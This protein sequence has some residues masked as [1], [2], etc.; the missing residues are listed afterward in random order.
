MQ[1]R[2]RVAVEAGCVADVKALLFCLPLHQ[3]DRPCD[4]TLDKSLHQASNTLE[5]NAREQSTGNTLLHCAVASYFHAL[6]VSKSN[7]GKP[8]C[9]FR[10][11][12]DHGKQHQEQLKNEK[13]NINENS[14]NDKS[15][16]TSTSTD[17]PAIFLAF[18]Q[19]L[20]PQ[21]TR[22][23]IVQ[24]LLAAGADPEQRNLM[25]LTPMQLL[26]QLETNQSY[27]CKLLN[28]PKSSLI[29]A[30]ISAGGRSWEAVPIPCPGIGQALYPVWQKH[31]ED[32][33]CLV[34]RLES[35]EKF[36]MQNILLL[37]HRVLPGSGHLAA[38]RMQILS[39]ALTAL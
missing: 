31:P 38:L 13:K 5:I 24:C 14:E 36:T 1:R 39:A 33:V 6:K 35:K 4:N 3:D 15:S 10:S 17:D 25:G 2:L 20:D 29:V 23:A 21:S 27:F 37:L 26:K 11:P 9:N 19:Q 34:F 16:S 32:L 30:L 22:M 18:Q 28:L 12:K 8:F 7:L